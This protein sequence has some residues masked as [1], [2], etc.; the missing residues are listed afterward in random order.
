MPEKDSGSLSSAR[1]HQLLLT[2]RRDQAY[3]GIGQG[4]PYDAER[5]VRIGR[6]GVERPIRQE[7]QKQIVSRIN[8]DL[9]PGKAGMTVRRIA[10]ESTE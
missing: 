2:Y 6:P 4:G 7:D 10:D 9:G 5:M 8:P 3:G 1:R